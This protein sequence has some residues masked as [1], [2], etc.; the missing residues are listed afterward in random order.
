MVEQEWRNHKAI[1]GG[2]GLCSNA[3]QHLSPC[4]S[5]CSD[6]L[7]KTLIFGSCSRTFFLER[8]IGLDRFGFFFR[9][10]ER[11]VAVVA[12]FQSQIATNYYIYNELQGSFHETVNFSALW[13]HKNRSRSVGTIFFGP[14]Y[15]RRSYT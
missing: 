1:R 6:G 2:V 4:P 9:E 3:S 5:N 14:A 11:D 8:K 13:F 12:E 7:L 15:P 10:R